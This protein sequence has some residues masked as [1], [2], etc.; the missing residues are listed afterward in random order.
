MQHK[1][2]ELEQVQAHID[3]LT[4]KAEL[5]DAILALVKQSGL[6]KPKQRRARKVRVQEHERSKPHAPPAA[7]EQPLKK[8]RASQLA[9]VPE[10]A[11]A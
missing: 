1:K 11:T 5:A 3:S 4:I 10:Q 9:A 6:L 2:T 7:V 8:K